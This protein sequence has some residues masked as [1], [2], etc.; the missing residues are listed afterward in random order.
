MQDRKFILAF[1]AEHDHAISE[2]MSTGDAVH[3]IIKPLIADSQESYLQAHL[4]GGYQD[5]SHCLITDLR[6]G[7]RNAII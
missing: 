2:D 7:H 4:L 6:P 3:Q 1:L 5:K